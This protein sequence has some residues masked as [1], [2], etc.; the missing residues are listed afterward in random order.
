M[1]YVIGG[2]FHAHWHAA[3]FA[4]LPPGVI[5]GILCFFMPEPKRDGAF[6]AQRPKWSDYTQLLRIPSYVIN[7]AAMTA[8]TFSLGGIAYFMARYLEEVAHLNPKTATPIFGAIAAAAGLLGT[9][10]GGIAGDKLRTKYPGSY[11]LVSAAGMFV[12][13]PLILLM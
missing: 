9:L 11:F 3:F 5:L 1:G 6:I 8:M 4:T 10:A 13:F 7:T 12:G 2:I